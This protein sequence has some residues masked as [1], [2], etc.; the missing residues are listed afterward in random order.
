MGGPRELNLRESQGCLQAKSLEPI[1]AKKYE[2]SLLR[3]T[4]KLQLP[5]IGQSV[6]NESKKG[7]L[8]GVDEG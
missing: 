3:D 4:N 2:I 6:L 8:A 5:V 1:S 7:D